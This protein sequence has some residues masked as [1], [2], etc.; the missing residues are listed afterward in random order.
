MLNT[1][2]PTAP[3]LEALAAPSPR[4]LQSVALR[5]DPAAVA[6]MEALRDRLNHPNRGAV[7]RFLVTEGLRHAE[8]TLKEA[9]RHALDRGTP[10]QPPWLTP[11]FPYPPQGC[12]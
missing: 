1:C 5:L 2:P 12:R 7:L 6:R 8:A 11:S 4:P 3:S 9:A 10:S